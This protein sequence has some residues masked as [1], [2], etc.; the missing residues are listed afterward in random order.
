[1]GIQPRTHDQRNRHDDSSFSSYQD[2]YDEQSRNTAHRPNRSDRSWQD[3]WYDSPSQRLWFDSPPRQ[4]SRRSP[5]QNRSY[6]PQQSR[7]P[8]RP[9]RLPYQT[10]G[11]RPPQRVFNDSPPQRRNNGSSQLHL[12]DT[13]RQ[14]RSDRLSQRNRS[15]QSQ[16]QRTKSGAG[17]HSSVSNKLNETSDDVKCAICLD[18]EDN[19]EMEYL[20]CGHGF[21]AKCCKDWLSING[22]CPVCRTSVTSQSANVQNNPDRN[23]DNI[24]TFFIGS[25][26]FG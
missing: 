2:P 21:H 19:P 6:T 11:D 15:D 25:V 20:P 1:M 23:V 17:S 16:Q 26:W 24:P 7:G 4:R 5:Q 3:E 8:F 10:Q 13:P 14:R 9:Q 22:L 18:T 12:N